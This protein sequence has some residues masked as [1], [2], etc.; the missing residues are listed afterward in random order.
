M[1]RRFC[2]A[3]ARAWLDRES[4]R[5]DRISLGGGTRRAL[6]RAHRRVRPARGRC[7]CHVGNP[8]SRRG[9]AGNI[10]HPDCVRDGG[11]PG[12]QRPCRESGAAGWQRHRPVDSACR[13]CWQAARTFARGRPPSRPVGDHGQCR[14]SHH[15]AGVGRGSGGGR[16]ARSRS[17]HTPNP[18]STGYRVRLRG[19]QGQRGRTLCLYR[20][21]HSNQPNSNQQLGTGRAT[22]DDAR[23]SGLR[24]SGRSDVLWSELSRPVSARG[25]VCRQD[26]AR[27][28]AGRHPGRAADQ[29]RSRHKSDHRQ[30]ARPRN[31]AVGARPRRRGNRMKRRDFITLLGGAAAWPLAARAQQLKLAQIGVLVLTSADGQSLTRELRLGLR[32]LGYSEGQNLVFQLRSADGDAAWLPHLATELVRSQVDVIVGT[33]TPC[34]LAAKQATTTIPIVMAAVAD[35]I[36]VGLVTSLVRPGGNVTGFSNMAAEAAGKSVELFRDMLPS[37]GRVAALAN[38]ADPFTTPFLDQVRLAGRTTGIRIEPIAMARGPEEVEAAF[39]TISREGAEAVVVQGIF[40][41]KPIA[42]LALRYRLPTASVV[43][44]FAQAGGP[45]DLPVELPTRFELVLNMKTA[46]ALGIDVPWF[47][48]QR[49]DEV[50]E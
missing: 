33:F 7:H 15:R 11:G 31:S 1:D 36:V 24:R 9:K 50:I 4:H 48:Q 21:A 35:P 2:A 12:R 18:R 6:S 14:Q 46:K 10:N 23:D 34:A 20:R 26:S 8:T 17:R 47:F 27:G 45:S 30:G 37:I 42:E 19:A 40:F 28:K 16:D 41:S 49:T 25:R 3:T 39:A 43:R 13:T 32:D 38:P 22:A 44:Q 29:V 5:R